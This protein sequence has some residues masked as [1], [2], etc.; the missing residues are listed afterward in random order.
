MAE[1]YAV[2]RSPEYLAHYGIKGMRWGVRRALE[3]GNMQKLASHYARA[4]RKNSILKERTNRKAQKEEAKSYAAGGAALLGA[5]A[6]GGLA[7]YGLIKAQTPLNRAVNKFA[8]TTGGT[9]MVPTGLIG[10]SGLSAAGGLA[11]LGAGAAS[12]YRS[13][14]RGNKKAIEKQK[15]FN[16]EMNKLF[17]KSTRRKIQKYWQ[18]HPEEREDYLGPK[19][20]K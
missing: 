11:S 2:E 8:G 9:Y 14:K 17:S 20:H 12:A 7:S 16:Q 1:Y 5:G 10:M 18:K 4:I 15:R 13:T 19:R 6:L 3:K